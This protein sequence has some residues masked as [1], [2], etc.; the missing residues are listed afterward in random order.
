[1]MGKNEKLLKISNEKLGSYAKL[2]LKITI[3]LVLIQAL[4]LVFFVLSTNYQLN[5]Y[6]VILSI[7]APSDCNFSVKCSYPRS[8]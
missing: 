1:M 3:P 6:T 7:C 4:G 8:T 2:V 5:F